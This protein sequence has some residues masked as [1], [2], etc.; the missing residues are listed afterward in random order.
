MQFEFANQESKDELV[1][2]VDKS[3]DLW[4][5]EGH[6]GHAE[7]K[8]AAELLHSADIGQQIDVPER[9][10]HAMGSIIGAWEEMQKVELIKHVIGVLESSLERGD[11]TVH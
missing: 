11:S 5:S 4:Q 10:H 1:R 6:A 2:L 9:L 8:E 7:L 3:V